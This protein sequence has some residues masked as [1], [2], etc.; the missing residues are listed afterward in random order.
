MRGRETRTTFSY[1]L[2]SRGA[3]FE[4]T[5]QKL[6]EDIRDAGF[7]DIPLIFKGDQEKAI[8]TFIEALKKD[9]ESAV[10]ERKKI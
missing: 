1:L 4:W 9:C 7:K 3:D 6:R 8:T 5:T 10:E 2:P